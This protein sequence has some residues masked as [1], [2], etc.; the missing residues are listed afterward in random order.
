MIVIK[1]LAGL[2]I[3]LTAALAIFSQFYEV[4]PAGQQQI[5]QDPAAMVAPPPVE[6]ERH[7]NAIACK[8]DP[9]TDAPQQFAADYL[10]GELWR[11]GDQHVFTARVA[12]PASGYVASFGQVSIAGT[13]AVVT[14]RVVKGGGTSL[15]MLDTVSMRQAFTLPPEVL[16]LRVLLKRDFAW[17][18]DALVCSVVRPADSAIPAVPAPVPATP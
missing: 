5:V 9:P 15:E 12:V 8:F 13:Q 10:Y 3:L 17:G 14:A 18:P 1:F 2:I 6:Y 11:N 7:R 16:T 4:V